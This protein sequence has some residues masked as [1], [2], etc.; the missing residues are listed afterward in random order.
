MNSS[1]NVIQRAD[2]EVAKYCKESVIFGAN[3]IDFR[4]DNC[5]WSQ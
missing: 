5:K 3:A 1:T 4:Y 2:R